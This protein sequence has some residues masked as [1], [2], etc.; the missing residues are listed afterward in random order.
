MVDPLGTDLSDLPPILIQA[1]TGDTLLADAHRLVEHAQRCDVAVTLQLYPVATHDFHIFWSFLP[2]AAEAL[3]HAGRFIATTT[4]RGA[5][6]ES[7]PEERP[8]RTHPDRTE[9]G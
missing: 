4:Q 6:T 5:A 2:E 7:R 8:A 1:G 9:S 3:R